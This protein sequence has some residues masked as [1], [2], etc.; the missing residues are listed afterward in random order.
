[1]VDD[2]NTRE[3]GIP[4][5]P[6]VRDLIAGKRRY[7]A[8]QEEQKA[9]ASLGF[10]GWSE[11]GYLPH[12]DEPGL[13]Q[14]VTFHLH[15]SLPVALRSEWEALLKIEDVEIRRR[16]LE[17]YLDKGRGSSYLR[18]PEIA[19]IVDT[20]LRYYHNRSFDLRA[21]VVMPNHVHALF[22]VRECPMRQ[23]L[24]SFKIYTARECNKLLGRRGEFW[25]D[26]LWDTF[27]RDAEHELRTKRYIENNPVKAKLSVFAKDWPWASARFRDE[28][29]RLKF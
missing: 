2:S 3:K 6:E 11:R 8:S 5:N 18:R 26:D 19:T 12:R 10:D 15:D 20:A 13:V 29:G 9:D 21:W 4:H 27:M 17:A 25:A 23:S 1:M 16:K 7:T 28:Y 22:K 14:F 24:R